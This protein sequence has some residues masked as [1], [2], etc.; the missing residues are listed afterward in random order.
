[1]LTKS[2]NINN[3]CNELFQSKTEA[4]EALPYAVGITISKYAEIPT[5]KVDNPLKFYLM[6]CQ[7][8]IEE[9]IDYIN[10]LFVFDLDLALKVAK[11]F[12][13][14]RYHALHGFPEKYEFI[15][16]KDFL[17]IMFGAYIYLSDNDINIMN[18]YAN[19]LPCLMANLDNFL[20]KEKD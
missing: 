16:N 4:L 9:D 19:E 10:E 13:T 18:K 15:G 7:K 2:L 12:W 5:D 20:S 3:L 6:N 8:Q 14:M 11:S 17:H 1:M